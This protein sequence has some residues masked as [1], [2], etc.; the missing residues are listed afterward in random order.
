MQQRNN[1]A[2]ANNAAAQLNSGAN[3]SGNII[4]SNGTSGSKRSS[5]DSSRS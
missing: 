4:R 3:S 5:G 2:G 1:K